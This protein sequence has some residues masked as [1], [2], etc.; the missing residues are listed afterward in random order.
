M[1]E[2]QNQ[3]QY[4]QVHSQAP[5]QQYNQVPPQQPCNSQINVNFQ[6][7]QPTKPCKYCHAPIS[8]FAKVCPVCK[9]RQSYTGII[10]GVSVAVLILFVMIFGQKKDPNESANTSSSTKV[11]SSS[12]VS[13]QT[14][15]QEE[16]IEYTAV[17]VDTLMSDLD[18]NAL[19]A[20]Q[21]YN[22]QYL[23]ITGELKVIDASGKYIGLYPVDSYS[24]NGCHCSIKND[25]QRSAVANMQTD[26]VITIKVK[27]T[28]VG[29]ILGYNA[30]I[31]E[32]E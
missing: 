8:V 7:Q 12:S 17:T 19:N 26:T 13:T 3:Q 1:N 5:Q 21:K 32:F 10:C 31:I 11:E 25:E 4:N 22:G 9:K 28:D 30:D 27:I 6:R 14:E 16:T 23:E 20:S 2:N 18:A 24:L 15:S 29:E